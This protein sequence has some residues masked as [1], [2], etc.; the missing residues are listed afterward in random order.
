MLYPR[1]RRRGAFT[2]IELLVVIAII[3]ILIA[4]LVPAVQK[5]REAAAR[6]QCQ[7]NLKQLGVALHN[8]HDQY[9]GFPKAGK[10][11]S[12]LSWHV[13]ILPYIEQTTLFTQFNF[14]AGAFNGA[15]GNRGP[16]KNEMALNRV[17]TFLCPASTIERMLTVAPNN[18]NLPELIDGTTAVYTTHYYGIMGP[19]GTSPVT[20]QPYLTVN[21]TDAHGGYSLEGP[22]MPEITAV[23]GV[24]PPVGYKTTHITDGTSNTIMVGEISWE[25]NITGTRYRSWVRGCDG[26]PVCAGVRNVANAINSP[27]IAL[28]ND[29][30]F[31]S[32]HGGGANFALADGSVRFLSADMNLTTYRSLASRAADEPVG[33]F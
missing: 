7:N 15:P 28:F 4:L 24:T 23:A 20:T 27:S 33:S 32:N 29:I 9:K 5:V 3:A 16:M 26:A 2:L 19:K 30:A 1:H 18:V 13:F 10:R 8:F 21:A 11:T 6:T 31:G 22:F 12:E 25:N 17:S 14:A